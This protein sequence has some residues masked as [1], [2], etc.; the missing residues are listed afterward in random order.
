[1]SRKTEK[2]T[3]KVTWS[4]LTLNFS[5]RKYLLKEVLMSKHL[6]CIAYL[7]NFKKALSSDNA[8]I[9]IFLAL[10]SKEQGVGINDYYGSLPAGD[11][12]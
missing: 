7:H 1:M 10:S 5:L 9:H 4:R 12:P 6:S 3:F 8:V 2:F 11:V